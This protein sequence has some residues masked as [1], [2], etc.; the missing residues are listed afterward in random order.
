MDVL[1][2]AKSKTHPENI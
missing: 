2:A 1:T